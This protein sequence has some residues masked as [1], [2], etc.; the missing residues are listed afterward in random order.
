MVRRSGHHDTPAAARAAPPHNIQL[1]PISR[2]IPVLDT[3]DGPGAS[4][5]RIVGQ[6]LRQLRRSVCEEEERDVKR[7]LVLCRADGAPRPGLHRSSMGE[8]NDSVEKMWSMTQILFVFVS[9]GS[10]PWFNVRF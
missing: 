4:R 5:V 9:F 1:F 7:I 6:N 2:G 3:E 10:V 8:S